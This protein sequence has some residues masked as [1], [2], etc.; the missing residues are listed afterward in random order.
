MHAAAQHLV[1]EH[2]FT[3]FRAG[4]CQAKSPIRTLKAIS[5]S[6]EGRM[7]SII[8]SAHSFLHHQV[9]NFVGTL[10]LVGE[11]KWRSTDVAKALAA[12]NRAV[13]GETAPAEGLFLTNVAYPPELIGEA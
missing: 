11:G 7:I 3:T 6:R 5:V 2:D 1:G 8:V 4:I 13:G 9:R 12:R 10:R